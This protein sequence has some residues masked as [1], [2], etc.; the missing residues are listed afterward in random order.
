MSDH[1]VKS[2]AG[3][4]D[5]EFDW[6]DWIGTD[7]IEAASFTVD[8]GVTVE[9]NSHTEKVVTVWLSGGQLYDVYG[10]RC[11]IRTQGGRIDHRTAML[12]IREGSA[13]RKWRI[14]PDPNVYG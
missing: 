1:F 2:P 12:T 4:L 13:S 7:V 3:N 5:F 14:A 9:S 8:A 6:S 11:S 10:V